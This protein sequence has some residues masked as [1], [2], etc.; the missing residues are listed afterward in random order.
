[1]RTGPFY[2]A[3]FGATPAPDASAMISSI[4]GAQVILGYFKGEVKSAAKEAVL[5]WVIGSMAVGGAAFLLAL[6]ALLK[7]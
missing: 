3:E 2:R 6:V 1:M 7:K 4:P 5:P